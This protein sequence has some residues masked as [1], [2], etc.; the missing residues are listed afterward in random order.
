[1]RNRLHVNGPYNYNQPSGVNFQASM[2][3]TNIVPSKNMVNMLTAK[4]FS[5]LKSFL[6]I[7]FYIIT[8]CKFIYRI[9]ILFETFLTYFICNIY[10]NYTFMIKVLSFQFSF[11]NLASQCYICTKQHFKG[12]YYMYNKFSIKKTNSFEFQ[13]EWIQGRS[14][15]YFTCVWF[16]ILWWAD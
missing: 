15:N 4:F 2:T 14:C 1:M 9:W 12:I 10:N 5:S 16:K 8:A 7:V 11:I 13:H 6:K 3:P